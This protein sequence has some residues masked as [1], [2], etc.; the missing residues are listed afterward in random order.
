MSRDK[1]LSIAG[2]SKHKY[3]YKSKNS[4]KGRKP[5]EKTFL[6]KGS[7]VVRVDNSEVVKEI[8]KTQS[9]PDTNYGYR[10][11][12]YELLLLGFIINHKKVYR[13]MKEHQ[14]LKQKH[15]KQ[16]REFV[17]YR[18][19]FP[20]KPLEVL[21]MDIKFVWVE[22]HRMHAFILTVIDTFTR[23]VLGRKTAYSL[24]QNAI[25]Q[26]WTEIIENHLQPNDCLKNNL[27]IEI[28]NDNDSRFIAK[29]VQ[30]FFLENKLQQ[31]FTHPYTPQENGHI[32]SFHAILS[33]RLN[34]TTFWSLDDLE[35]CLV[36]FYEKYNFHRLHSSIAYLPPMIFWEC[37]KKGEIKTTFN[38]KKKQIK[39]KLLTPYHKLSGKMNLREVPCQH[40]QIPKGFEK[41]DKNE[42]NGAETFLQPSV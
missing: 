32:E 2:L 1:A 21:E 27:N 24:K 36:L 14:L 42:M 19:V 40:P 12:T 7:D 18:K 26:L 38:E 30:K 15:R 13:L 10:K 35:Q 4:R 3:Y 5:S 28:R 17:K 33:E 9:D 6:V 41:N 16:P 25:K 20:S 39:H 23:A 37:W 11:M 29:S 31:V 22:E 8:E 34:R